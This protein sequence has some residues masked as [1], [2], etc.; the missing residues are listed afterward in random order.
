MA[1]A[2]N[3]GKAQVV[4]V[5]DDGG[6]LDT[7]FNDHL[8]PAAAG[9][10]AAIMAS[11][12]T[13]ATPKITTHVAEPAGPEQKS[14]VTGKTAKPR[15]RR[16]SGW[17]RFAI[18]LVVALGVAFGLR[19][20]VVAPYYIPSPSMETTLH[21]CTG[22]DNDHVLVDKLSYH[23]HG[24]HRGDVVVFNRPASWLSVPDKVLI[25]RV[26]GLPGD[27]LS[28]NS[29]HLFVNGVQLEEPYLDAN[30]GPMTTLG[31]GGTTVTQLAPVP[32]STYF[33][34]GDNRCQSDDSRINGP[35]PRSSIIGRAFLIIWPL[36]RIHYL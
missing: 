31:N 19:T 7:D 18:V 25:K 28:L 24:V 6:I 17:A 8:V 2:V 21:G 1:P 11:A 5:H 29:G 33:V 10:A 12:A 14:E 27:R 13:D 26:I 23:L 32:P 22:C 34:M 16:T 20:Y 15:R 3:L 35:I 36:G 4:D 30:C 9:A